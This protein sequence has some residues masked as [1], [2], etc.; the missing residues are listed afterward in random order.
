MRTIEPRAAL[1]E[2]RPKSA[3]DVAI[4][5]IKRWEGFRQYAY[6][7]V[8]GIWTIG[9]GRAYGVK[10]G[11]YVTEAQ[12]EQMLAEDLKPTFLAIQDLQTQIP[13]ALSIYQRGALASFAYNVGVS[14]LRNSKSVAGRLRSGDIEGAA[15]G[16]LLY[17]KARVDGALVRIRGLANRRA[18]ERDVFLTG[19]AIGEHEIDGA[20]M[21]PERPPSDKMGS[22]EIGGAMVGSTAATSVIALLIPELKTWP[23]ELQYGVG[24]CLIL[25]LLAFG[26]LGV[27]R[28]QRYARAEI[29]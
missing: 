29:G 21:A 4:E 26:Y 22:T 17:N 12:A 3:R 2:Q 13:V 24:G 5:L 25:T 14:A 1:V 7:D 15:D 27:R 23:V 18:D 9:Y 10:E 28:Y 16:L 11:D 19:V 20:T 6:R 8:G